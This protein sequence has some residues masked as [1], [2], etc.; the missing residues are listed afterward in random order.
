MKPPRFSEAATS[1]GEKVIALAASVESAPLR[2]GGWDEVMARAVTAQP[3]NTKLV[4]LFLLS[5]AAG[6]AL[7]LLVR[8]MSVAAP[9]VSVVNATAGSRWSSVSPQEVTLQ[10]G[11]LSVTTPSGAPLHVRTPDAELEVTRSRF[12]AEVVPAGTSVW[13][14]EG[15]VVLRAG[16]VTRVVRAGQSLTWPPILV[17]PAPLLEA[18]PA[19]DSRCASLSGAEIRACL[20][21]E[22]SG[23]SLEA[24]AALY[25]L[26]NFEVKHGQLDA[27]LQVWRESLDRFPRGVLEP[28]VRLSLLVAMVKA[29]RFS[30][31]RLAAQEFE[32]YCSDD[33][34][35]LDVRALRRALPE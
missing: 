16:G 21:R 11:R 24:Q 23:A 10:S 22:A 20:R 35:A 26:G 18:A 30:E 1:A 5:V 12:L 9:A 17:I 25:E 27:G 19:P 32:A 34:R 28:E 7:V 13:V 29:H 15:E 8:P 3:S 4:P 6:A 14:E 33:P 31:A 2:A